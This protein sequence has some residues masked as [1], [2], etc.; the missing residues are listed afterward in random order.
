[1]TGELSIVVVARSLSVTVE[2][3]ASAVA[4]PHSVQAVAVPI[5]ISC[6]VGALSALDVKSASYTPDRSLTFS[7]PQ[8]PILGAPSTLDTLLVTYGTTPAELA[9]IGRFFGEPFR[10]GF[11]VVNAT[12]VNMF[13][14]LGTPGTGTSAATYTVLL[15]PGAYWEAPYGYSGA[16][17]YWF[18][19][20]GAGEAYF[21][22]LGAV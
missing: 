12:A 13:L 3:V 2:A 5:E 11:T 1:L 4:F 17:D 20:A 15:V 9:E 8:V 6:D 19:A 21:T 7:A 16:A 18:A 22:V 14:L 10:R